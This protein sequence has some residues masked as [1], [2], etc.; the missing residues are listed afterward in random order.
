MSVQAC[1]MRV[2]CLIC[3][4]KDHQGANTVSTISCGD[5]NQYLDG[6]TYE[7][8]RRGTVVTRWICF[9]Q[10]PGLT[11][12]GKAHPIILLRESGGFS[13]LERSGWEPLGLL[14]YLLAA[15]GMRKVNLRTEGRP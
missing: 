8:S 12:G 1:A 4:N 10:A 11:P 5:T 15:G 3:F 9:V 13:C 6:I 7:L 14:I 2:H